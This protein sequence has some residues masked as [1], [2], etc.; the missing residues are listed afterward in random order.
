[1]IYEIRTYYLKTHMLQEYWKRFSE[2]L[3]GRSKLL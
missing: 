1:M 2:K 3:P